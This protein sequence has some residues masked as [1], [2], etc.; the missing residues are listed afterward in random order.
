MSRDIRRRS[1]H[2]GLASS[3]LIQEY[4]EDIAALSELPVMD[5]AN[6]TLIYVEDVKSIYAYEAQATASANGT[7]IISPISSI[8]RWFLVSSNTVSSSGSGYG[9]RWVD[10]THATITEPIVVL[11]E[12]ECRRGKLT[13]EASL[14]VDPGGLVYVTSGIASE[15]R[16][17]FFQSNTLPADTWRS[18][19]QPDHLIMHTT[20]DKPFVVN[21]HLDVSGDLICINFFNVA[22]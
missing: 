7:T 10:P 22:S 12:W 17:D 6:G 20:S 1:L 3:D 15:E 5:N 16:P 18:I 14:T 2:S 21:G 11:D 19:P 4:V 9:D 8:G 13:I